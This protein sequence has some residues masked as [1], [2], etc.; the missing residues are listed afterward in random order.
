M[1]EKEAKSSTLMI[2]YFFLG[3]IIISN[4]YELG[5]SNETM[6]GGMLDGLFVP[7]K[8]LASFFIRE[9]YFEYSFQTVSHKLGMILGVAIL[10][11]LYSLLYKK[12]K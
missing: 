5:I 3:F 2:I 11:F 10:I 6:F 8:L 4:E 12:T 7:V 9:I 1:M